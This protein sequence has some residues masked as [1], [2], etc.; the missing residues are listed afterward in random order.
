M[1]VAIIGDSFT[2][3]YNDTWIENICKELN[4]NVVFHVGHRGHSQFK[5]YKSFL[6][7]LNLNP[8]VIIYVYT[9]YSRLYNERY[10]LSTNTVFQSAF[11]NII[12]NPE[13][14][15]ATQHY[16]NHLYDDSFAKTIDID[17]N[18]NSSHFAEI[19]VQNRPKIGENKEVPPP[20]HRR[21]IP[22]LLRG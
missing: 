5:I 18:F 17:G 22:A 13:L 2:H 7:C 9:A 19:C 16:Y 1:R 4:F 20:G 8:D 11:A 14:K 15:K 6:D 3:T 10:P 21:S 12:S